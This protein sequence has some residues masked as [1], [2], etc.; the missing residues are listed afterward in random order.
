MLKQLA[1]N[2]VKLIIIQF[3]VGFVLWY[4]IE[5]T[6][7]RDELGFGA[8]GVSLI[9][10]TYLIVTLL[11]EVPSGILADKWGRKNVLVTS[12]LL[13]IVSNIVLGSSTTMGMYLVGTIIWGL[14]AVT[15][16]GT[17]ESITYDSLLS[18][19]RSQ[20][21]QKVDAYQNVAFMI[22]IFI[23]SALAGWVGPQFGLKWTFYLSVIPLLI[24]LG[25]A[26]T[27]KEPQLHKSIAVQSVY[28]H[29]KQ[30]F[31]MILKSDVLSRVALLLGFVLLLQNFLYEYSQYY[32]LELFDNNVSIAAVLNGVT[33]LFLAA[34][35]ALAV[36]VH[37]FERMLLGCGIMM[38]IAGFWLSPWAI[39][40]FCCVYPLVAITANRTQTALQHGLVSEVRA[41]STSVV[42]FLSSLVII[43]LSFGFASL[44]ESV[45]AQSAYLYASLLFIVA[46]IMFT[47]T[48]LSTHSGITDPTIIGELPSK[49]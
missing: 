10:M 30:A 34:G 12:I 8:L 6:F 13:F 14:H 28:K 49:P 4:G 41:T 35:F 29:A 37:R 18:Q 36:K 22:G 19:N 20:L 31:G 26:L 25:L 5:K 7:I 16:S 17:L 24:A 32:Y 42:N 1:S 45:G 40:A 38:A 33:G 23:S 3:L 21:F 47:V 11:L 2:A 39:V 9:V 46:G 48:K 15:H 27:I 44:I 43:P